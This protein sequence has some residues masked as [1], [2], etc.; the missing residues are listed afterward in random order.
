VNKKFNSNCKALHDGAT[1]ARTHHACPRKKTSPNI[2][3]WNCFRKVINNR[4]TCSLPVAIG[5]GLRI[6]KTRFMGAHCRASDVR[7]AA[8]CG[9]PLIG[10]N[11]VSSRRRTGS[12]LCRRELVTH[13]QSVR[14]L[15]PA[16]LTAGLPHSRQSITSQ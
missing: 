3:C 7:A 10:Q 2:H 14:Q 6:D 5:M 16:G 11:W 8:T 9:A 13:C 15:A 1:R 4:G 12:S